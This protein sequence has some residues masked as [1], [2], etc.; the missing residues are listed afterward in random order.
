MI[1]I[2]THCDDAHKKTTVYV[3]FILFYFFLYIQIIVWTDE[4]VAHGAL[5]LNKAV[6]GIAVQCKGRKGNYKRQ[7]Q[8]NKGNGIMGSVW[9]SEPSGLPVKRIIYSF[10]W[11]LLHLESI[12]VGSYNKD[13]PRGSSLTTFFRMLVA[14]YSKKSYALS[15]DA[16]EL[17]YENLVV[18]SMP[19]TNSLRLRAKTKLHCKAPISYQC[20]AESEPSWSTKLTANFD[21]VARQG[22]HYSSSSSLE[23][24]KS[25]RWK[26][27]S[28]TEVEEAKVFVYMIPLWIN[29]AICGIVTSVGGT[30]FME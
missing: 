23:K 21:L 26:L 12:Q 19:H 9:S 14:S 13:T 30:Y 7:W 16:N 10:V 20:L 25:N 1:L 11:A 4:H 5:I 28:V 27:C 3:Y 22:C 18:P 6:I 15:I 8:P 29:F 24:Q 17:Y 2:K